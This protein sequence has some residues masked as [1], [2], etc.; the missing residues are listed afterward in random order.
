M[1]LRILN[2]QNI[3]IYGRNPLI[4][5]SKYNAVKCFYPLGAGKESL[6]ATVQQKNQQLQNL[7]TL[8]GKTPTH[9]PLHLQLSLLITSFRYLNLHQ[10][11]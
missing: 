7:P 6:T 4:L 2:K 8:R 3:S 5:L 11:V 1:F 10:V 9:C